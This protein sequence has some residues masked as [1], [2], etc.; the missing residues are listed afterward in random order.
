[1]TY[2]TEWAGQTDSYVM[3]VGCNYNNALYIRTFDLP[4]NDTTRTQII[5]YRS[6]KVKSSE[7]PTANNYLNI[8]L[9]ICGLK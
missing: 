2:P 7:T 4:L 1:M 9:K 8:P 5:V 6:L 3:A